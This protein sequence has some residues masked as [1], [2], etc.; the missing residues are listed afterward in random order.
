MKFEGDLDVLVQKIA[1]TP[2]NG[3][4]Q[5]VVVCTQG[6]NPTLIGTK[7]QCLKFDIELVDP[8]KIV[9]TNSAGDSFCGGYFDKF[10]DRFISQLVNGDDLSKCAKAGNYSAA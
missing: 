9:D 7:D 10:N 2:K 3:E 5:R 4:R 1:G 8:S 6:K